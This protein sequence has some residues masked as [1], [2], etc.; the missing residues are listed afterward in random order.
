MMGYNMM[1]GV[2]TFAIIT[3]LLVMIDLALLGVWLWKRISKE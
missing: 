1:G 2:G 3:W